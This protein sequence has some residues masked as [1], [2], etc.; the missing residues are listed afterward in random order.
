M[1]SEIIY[2]VLI[3][4]GVAAIIVANKFFKKND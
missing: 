3:A 4:I 1:N 2:G